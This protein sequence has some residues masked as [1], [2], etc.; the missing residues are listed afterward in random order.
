MVCN[1]AVTAATNAFS[2]QM[3][4]ADTPC[5][6]AIAASMSPFAFL[7]IAVLAVAGCSSVAPPVAPASPSTPAQKPAAPVTADQRAAAQGA[8]AAERA[9]LQSW[10][11]GTPVLIAQRADGAI[12]I[13][14]PREFCFDAGSSNVKPAL[15]AVL[16]KLAESLKRVPLARVPLLAAPD[17]GSANTV[18]ALQRAEQVH[19]HLLN[20]GVPAARLGKPSASSSAAVRLRMETVPL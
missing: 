13:D 2:L 9:W 18:L 12:T 3:L 7:L 20:Q 10:F 8:V 5:S 19:Q 17:D 11:K 16:N 4:R 15:A 6:V 1:G 14:V